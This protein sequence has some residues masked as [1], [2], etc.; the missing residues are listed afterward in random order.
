MFLSFFPCILE[1][2]QSDYIRRDSSA[3]GVM[4]TP[5]RIDRIFIKLCQKNEIFT[6]TLMSATT[7][8][9]GP[10]RVTS[11]Q[12]A[13]SFKSQ[14]FE[15]TRAN[16]FPAGC[17]NIPILCPTLQQLH[18]DHR[19]P[20]DPSF[21]LAEFKVLLHKAKKMTKRELSRQTPD[22]IGAKLLIASAAL[23]SYGNRNLG[24]LMRFCEAWK[25][26][27]D[28]FDT[29]SFK[30]FDFQ[31]LSQIIANLSRVTLEEREADLP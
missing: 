7:W 1:I 6:V 2:A 22:C 20:P 8:G 9:I 12:Y 14:Q 17:P 19:F 23:R 26:V 10:F 5:S 3:L 16:I 25:L 21:A 30:S 27:E 24:A 13:S 31:R 28:C 4:R 11:Q 29:S 15:D 18:D